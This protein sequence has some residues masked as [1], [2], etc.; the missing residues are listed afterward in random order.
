VIGIAL[1]ALVVYVFVLGM[2]SKDKTATIDVQPAVPTDINVTIDGGKVN[3]NGK[4]A[5]K[6]GK[7][8]VTAKRSGF[9]DKTQ[10]VNVK[11][12]E[13]KTVRL[14]LTPI[15]DEGYTWARN[16]PEAFSEYEAQ[17]S[18]T[19]DTNS[20]DLTK[21]YPLIAQLP[22]IHPTWRVDYGKSVAHPNDSNS[23]AIIITHGGDFGK[24][25]ALDWIKSQGFNPADYEI[26]LKTPPAPG[27]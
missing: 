17:S 7:H 6:P 4:V 24:Q 9:A 26:V 11:T 21:K 2:Q 22:E 10:D 5:V 16:H 14:L 27:D 18:A 25:S 13:T 3:S 1:F 19:F 23:L 15:N 12:G 8:T 20:V